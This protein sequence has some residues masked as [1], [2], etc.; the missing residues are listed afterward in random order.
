MISSDS[1]F[2][3]EE[4]ASVVSWWLSPEHQNE[5]QALSEHNFLLSQFLDMIEHKVN[6]KLE[7]L[8]IQNS[9]QESSVLGIQVSSPVEV[10]DGNTNVAFE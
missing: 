2:S 6:E 1:D 4:M 9:A 5:R 10:E 3:I 7:I 8:Q